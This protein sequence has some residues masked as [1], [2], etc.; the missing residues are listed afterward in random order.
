[1]SYASNQSARQLFCAIDGGLILGQPIDR[2]QAESWPLG[3]EDFSQQLQNLVQELERGRSH[4]DEVQLRVGAD[5]VR[6]RASVL[7]NAGADAGA[8]MVLRKTT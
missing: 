7:R 3:S 1:M 6:C 4:V 8:V 2:P 5:T